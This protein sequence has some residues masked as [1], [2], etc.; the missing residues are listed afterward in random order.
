MELMQNNIDAFKRS[1]TSLRSLRDASIDENRSYTSSVLSSYVKDVLNDAKATI[2]HDDIK[3][4]EMASNDKIPHAPISPPP[5]PGADSRVSRSSSVIS[6][7]LKDVLTNVA[8]ELNT[9]NKKPKRT[10]QYAKKSSS[11]LN[12]SNCD[13]TSIA[14]YDLQEYVGDILVQVTKDIA[15]EK[16]LEESPSEHNESNNDNAPR[17]VMSM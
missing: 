14:S 2:I 3:K 13:T 11:D 1:I 15:H 4:T 10:I 7:Y 9:E 8:H 12:T 16:I 6:N 5:T 17:S